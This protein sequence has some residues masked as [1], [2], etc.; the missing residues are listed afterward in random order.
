LHHPKKDGEEIQGY[1]EPLMHARRSQSF[2][3]FTQR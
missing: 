1:G 3:E 2:H